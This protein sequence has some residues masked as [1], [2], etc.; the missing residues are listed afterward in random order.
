MAKTADP[1][2]IEST[3]A[4]V[5][6]S[7]FGDL[8]AVARCSDPALLTRLIAVLSAFGLR[9]LDHDYV[10]GKTYHGKGA[11][12]ARGRWHG[13]TPSR[14]IDS[15]GER[16]RPVMIRARRGLIVRPDSH[17]PRARQAAL[18]PLI[19]EANSHLRETGVGIVRWAADPKHSVDGWWSS[20][21]CFI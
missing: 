7:R 4:F 21:H 1:E 2:R 18:K 11:R 19:A 8:V 13:E 6:L 14:I 12:L 17:C 15:Y 9:Y 20:M 5:V 16:S 10:A 3:L